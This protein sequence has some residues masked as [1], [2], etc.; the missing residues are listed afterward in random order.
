MRQMLLGDGL[1]AYRAWAYPVLDPEELLMTLREAHA[2]RPDLWHAW[3]A[4]AQQLSDMGHHDEAL[5]ILQ[6]AVERFPS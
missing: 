6:E 4:L 1:L 5:G 2:E 3:S